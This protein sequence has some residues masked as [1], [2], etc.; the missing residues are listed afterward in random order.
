MPYPP[1][2]LQLET[3]RLTLRPWAITDA[4]DHRALAAERGDGTPS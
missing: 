2:P 4:D 1:M 3:A